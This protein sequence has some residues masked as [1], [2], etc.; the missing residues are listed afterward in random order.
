MSCFDVMAS[1]FG[2][3]T[4]G[5]WLEG[6]GKFILWRF[7]LADGSFEDWTMDL[8]RIPSVYKGASILSHAT[9]R[10]DLGA[11]ARLMAGDA[12]ADDLTVALKAGLIQVEGDAR[13]VM[14]LAGA[15]LQRRLS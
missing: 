7:H 9:V 6:V 4:N 12:V 2:E 5:A 8:V 11:A 13:M 15:A 14:R 1:L 10:I 3:L